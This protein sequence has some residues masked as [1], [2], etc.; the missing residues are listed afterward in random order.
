MK[1]KL[2][3]FYDRAYRQGLVCSLDNSFSVREGKDI[4]CLSDS[5]REFH[6]AIYKYHDNIN[7]VFVAHPVNAMSFVIK[8]Q[9]INTRLIPES[10]M[11][12]QDIAY[13]TREEIDKGWDHIAGTISDDE[14]AIILENEAV[15]TIG[16]TLLKTFD[17][18]EVLEFSAKAI[19]NTGS[20]GRRVEISDKDIDELKI[21]LNIR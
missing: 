11:V 8:K 21:T 9:K 20:I 14:T 16:P 5:Y 15:V 10:Y 12:L 1:D 4:F 17:R 2:K 18:L 7:A 6:E 19:I 3:Q 13:F